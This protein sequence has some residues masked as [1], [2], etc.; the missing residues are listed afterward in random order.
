MFEEENCC[1]IQIG[2]IRV[3]HSSSRQCR[4]SNFQWFERIKVMHN[5]F[6]LVHVTY[7]FDLLILVLCCFVLGFKARVI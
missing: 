7:L 3:T 2:Y 4:V 1:A 5:R 6:V